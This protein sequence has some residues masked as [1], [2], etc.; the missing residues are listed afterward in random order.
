MGRRFRYQARQRIRTALGAD[1]CL[2]GRPYLYGLG[3]AGEHGVT[4]ALTMLGDELRRTIQLL[5]VSSVD[6]LRAEGAELLRRYDGSEAGAGA[7]AGSG[8]AAPGG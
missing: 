4:A 6:R 2:I 5:A 1:A 7:G 8:A 3:A